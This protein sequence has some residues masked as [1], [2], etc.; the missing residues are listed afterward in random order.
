MDQKEIA[1]HGERA[2]AQNID[3]SRLTKSGYEALVIH[4]HG[5]IV[6]GNEAFAEIV[7]CAVKDIPGINAW[8]LYPPESIKVVMEK[9]SEA[10]EEPYEVAAMTVKGQPLLVRLEAVNFMM[11]GEPGRVMGVKK[12]KNL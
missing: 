1:R 9:L 2:L 3:Y 12:L 6:W 4:F 5:T 8:T 10:S 7:D 11:S